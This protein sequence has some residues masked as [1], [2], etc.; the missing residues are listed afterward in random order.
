VCV[1]A[2]LIE[3]VLVNLAVNARDAMPDGGAL[4]IR[5]ANAAVHAGGEDAD[6]ELQPGEYATI[7]VTDT[8]TGM[9]PEVKARIFEPFFTTKAKGRG[10]GLGLATAYG[11]VKQS[12]GHIL[13]D[14]EPGRGTT[15]R[16]FLPRMTEVARADAAPSGAEPVPRGTETILVVED[17]ADV[18]VLASRILEALGYAVIPAAS[19]EDAIA[20]AKARRDGIDLL[21]T[22]VVMPGLN[23]R[24]VANQIAPIHPRCRVLYTSGYTDEAIVHRG[25]LED[26]IAFLAKPYTPVA[27]GLKVR[28]VL[29]RGARS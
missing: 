10:T 26:G 11:T 1:D 7:S 21:L 29:D 4:G 27:L 23:G 5:T 12:G 19:G 2:G 9:P 18:R 22:D 17:D 8:G 14:S 3:Q 20:A 25:V 24:Q 15:F 6:P 28:E 13:V 16:V